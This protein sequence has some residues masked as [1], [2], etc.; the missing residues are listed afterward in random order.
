[1]AELY[2]NLLFLR[3]LL[4]FENLNFLVYEPIWFLSISGDTLRFRYRFSGQVLV[5]SIKKN[6]FAFSNFLSIILASECASAR[7]TEDSEFQTLYL[8]QR[9]NVGWCG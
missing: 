8:L 3:I 4:Y 9:K 2:M 6:S 7:L 5:K 1:M